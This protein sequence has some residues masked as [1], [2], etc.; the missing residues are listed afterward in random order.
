M[1]GALDGATGAGVGD[2]SNKLQFES[3]IAEGVVD[4]VIVE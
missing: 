2:A 3:D 1:E 4:V